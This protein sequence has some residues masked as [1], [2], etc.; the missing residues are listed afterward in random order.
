M[1][2]QNY[3]KE[4]LIK[5]INKLKEE[6]EKL[7]NL[8]DLHGI[9]LNSEVK[10]FENYNKEE[11]IDIY[12]SYFQGNPDYVA[13][14]YF[15][16]AQN[17]IAYAPLCL[18]K[19]K[20]GCLLKEKKKCKDCK[21]VNYQKYDKDIILKHLKGEISLGLYPIKDNERVK[22]IALD[23]DEKDYKKEVLKVKEIASYYGIDG[24][25]EISKSG[26][27]AH[28]WIFFDEWVLAK[29]AR[30]IAHFLL[31]EAFEKGYI[32]NLDSFDRLVP[33]QDKTQDSNKFGSLIALPLSGKMASQNTTIFVDE[34]FEKY[35]NQFGY[36]A[37]V[38]KVDLF[39][40]N[41]LLNKIYEEEKKSESLLGKKV[42][43][44]AKD[45]KKGLTLLIDN[46]IRINKSK[47]TKVS[48]NYLKSISSLYNPTYF[49]YQSKGLSTFKEPI[50]F[51]LYEEDDLEIS[52]PRGVLDT[53]INALK[54]KHVDYKIIDK[55]IEGEAIDI[56]FLGTLKAEQV[57]AQKVM[58]E[59]DNGIL[60][61]PTAFG[62][63]ILAISLMSE[64]KRNTLILVEKLTL[65]D[66]WKEKILSFTDLK[67]DDIGIF[68]TGKRK[69][70]GKVDI[71][72]IKS[73]ESKEM[74]E[75]IYSKY[76]LVIIDEVH[77][78]AADTLLS[79]VR[80]LH[81]RR[82]Y[83]L[84]ATLKRSDKN[85]NRIKKIL[86]DVLYEVKE[87]NSSFKRILHPIITNFNRDLQDFE[88]VKGRID[89]N[90][91]INELY[92]DEDRNE[93]I[94][95]TL[96]P[97]INKHNILV[98]TERIEHSEILLRLIKAK[99]DFKNIYLI[100]GS[101][102]KK[103]QEAFK[104]FLDN[105]DEDEKVLIIS[106]GKYIGEG[107]DLTRLDTLFV[108][109][110]IKWEGTLQQYVGRLHRESDNK[111]EVHVYDFVDLKIG[112]FE[113]AFNI[114]LSKYHKL[115]YLGERKEE[116]QII[117]SRKDYYKTLIN[118]FVKAKTNVS[119]FISFGYEDAIYSFLKYINVPLDIYTHLEFKFNENQLVKVHFK[120]VSLNLILIDE[121][122]IY[123]GDLNPFMFKKDEEESL[124]RIIDSKYA[125][126]LVHEIGSDDPLIDLRI[127]E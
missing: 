17:K 4:E 84:T 73:L 67:E 69:L 13:E 82:M 111:K 110:P 124:L 75:S 105:L 117:F 39:T 57:K 37:S 9:S 50:F 87:T 125:K 60:V 100:N 7:K 97:L 19:F 54:L 94:L 107:F 47:L 123:F 6:N 36:L 46:T 23:F 83:G 114:R 126:S 44:E 96:L 71:V 85:E 74:D 18:N 108:T 90:K 55:R 10:S 76:G 12:F 51:K 66:Q 93:L 118:D 78:V 120:K 59:K 58:L 24:A 29:G 41:Q 27:G 64:I 40:Y 35:Q 92:L 116:E 77:H 101:M 33:N 22:L 119:F 89:Y 115:Y 121:K 20:E 65:I 1:E 112:I 32:D 62:K 53:L 30:K 28:F 25:I 91:L 2:Y 127:D 95:N 68:K 109:M 5:E 38:K 122:I 43:F 104:T 14:E 63:T 56:N 11:K 34:Y 26:N 113:R 15:N 98:L 52:L 106:T 86:G 8:L 80:K 61:A 99:S 70:T 49:E 79:S 3:S 88:S 45:F 42:F 72:S 31:N 103:E 81:S 102:S 21:L 48:L 16:K